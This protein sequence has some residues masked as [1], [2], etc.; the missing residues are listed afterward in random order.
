MSK[1]GSEFRLTAGAE[2]AGLADVRELPVPTLEERARLLLR[3]VYGERDFTSSEHSNAH[4]S[5]LNAMAAGIAAKSKSGMPDE[6]PVKP[7]GSLVGVCSD[8]DEAYREVSFA[9]MAEHASLQHSIRESRSSAEPKIAVVRAL[10]PRACI[11]DS[12]PPFRAPTHKP[13]KRRVF[14]WS[15]T[16][17]LFAGLCVLGG[18]TL[19][20]AT[21]QPE[22]VIA[23][24]T[25]GGAPA[26]PVTVRHEQNASIPRPPLTD[27]QKDVEIDRQLQLAHERP[28]DPPLPLLA[29]PMRQGLFGIAPAG[30]FAPQSNVGLLE[31]ARTVI[32][33]GDIEAVRAALSKLVESGNSSA[34]VDLGTTYDPNILDALSVRNFPADVAKARV[35]Y[36]RAQQM[37]APEA[38]GLLESLDRSERGR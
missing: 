37:G 22:S 30:L 3:A 23:Q 28:P 11:D 31:R 32:A 12:L 17:S 26:A 29:L 16:L 24:S 20:R 38:V 14:V 15:A 6:P 8:E 2:T 18:L 35:W 13:A 19:Y 27:A 33:T 21:T 36:Q 25:R 1:K 4:S 10:Q 5:I 34:A 7:T 9:E